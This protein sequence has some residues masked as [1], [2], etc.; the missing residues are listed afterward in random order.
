MDVDHEFSILQTFQ[1]PGTDQCQSLDDMKCI[2]KLIQFANAKY[3]DNICSVCEKYHITGCLHDEGMKRLMDI[4]VFLGSEKRMDLDGIRSKMYL[5]EISGIL[6]LSERNW[7]VL[8]I[9]AAV[10]DSAEFYQFLED[11][12]F[13]GVEGASYFK[14]QHNLITEHLQHEEYNEQVLNQLQ[15]AFNY[16]SPF[17]DTE[18]NLQQLVDEVY[19]SCGQA[20]QGGKTDFVQLYTVNEHINLVRQWFSRAEVSATEF[21]HELQE[22]RKGEGSVCMWDMSTVISRQ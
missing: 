6:K 16:I 19:S 3:I 10:E 18:R 17:L 21:L 11:K 7:Y 8:R 1:F 12:K 4:N 5:E 2:F 22:G 20:A 14:Q 15:V 9:F 13:R